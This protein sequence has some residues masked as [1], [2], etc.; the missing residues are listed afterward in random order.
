MQLF[1]PEP[2]KNNG[3]PQHLF[4][5]CLV[6][7]AVQEVILS[8]LGMNSIHLMYKEQLRAIVL[9]YEYDSVLIFYGH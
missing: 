6:G 8:E 5:F 7:P 2:R 3:F 9:N 1:L 4:C